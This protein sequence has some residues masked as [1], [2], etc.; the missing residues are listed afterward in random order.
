ME[1]KDKAILETI[2]KAITEMS[3]F[4]KG[5]F[6]GV[7]ENQLREKEQEEKKSA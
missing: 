6:L 5:Y 7:A 3:D 1:E 4:D 2:A